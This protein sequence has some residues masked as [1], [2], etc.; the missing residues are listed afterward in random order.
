MDVKL[1]FSVTAHKNL[2]C[3]SRYNTD[4]NKEYRFIEY[5][6]G[7]LLNYTFFTFEEFLEDIFKNGNY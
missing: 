7:M 2:R 1:L 4:T 6:T 5:F 3:C